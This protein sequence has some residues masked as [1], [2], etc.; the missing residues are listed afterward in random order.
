MTQSTFYKAPAQLSKFA[1]LVRAVVKVR[2]IVRA[3]D[4]SVVRVVIV[5]F[6]LDARQI[7]IHDIIFAFEA[8]TW[9]TIWTVFME[10]TVLLDF[11]V[12]CKHADTSAFFIFLLI[13]LVF[14]PQSHRIFV[15]EL[16]V[17][18]QVVG[19]IRA[20]AE[21]LANAFVDIDGKKAEILIR[22]ALSGGKHRHR[23][24]T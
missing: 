9:T 14:I 4:R 13:I 17:F 16:E 2:V 21:I 19:K 11:Q 23:L 15:S 8:G 18:I 1:T 7:K 3:G 5:I 12:R 20:E 6:K 22:L 24:D 10:W